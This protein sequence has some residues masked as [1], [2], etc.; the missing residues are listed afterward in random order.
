M[1]AWRGGWTARWTM[2]EIRKKDHWMGRC[3][4]RELDGHWIK[5]NYFLFLYL[6][7]L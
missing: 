2:A 7:K 1:D 5:N 6:R 4:A 3:M